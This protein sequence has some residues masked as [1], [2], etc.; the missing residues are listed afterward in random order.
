VQLVF[1]FISQ[2]VVALVASLMKAAEI[3]VGWLLE[4]IC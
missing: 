4:R 2:V 3:G 1:D